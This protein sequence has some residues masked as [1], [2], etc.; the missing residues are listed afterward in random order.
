MAKFFQDGGSLSD[1]LTAI[2]MGGKPHTTLMMESRGNNNP[3]GNDNKVTKQPKGEPTEDMAHQMILEAVAAQ[4]ASV[5]LGDSAEAVFMWASS[6]D[7]SYDSLDAYAQS[8]AGIGDDAE[9]PTDDEMDDYYNVLAEMANFMVS[10]GIDEDA[11]SAFFDEEDDEMGASIA[12]QLND[13]DD[14]EK[15]ELVATYSV[16]GDD[17]MTEALKKVVRN[18]KVKLIRKP[19]KKRRRTAAQRMA[20]KKAQ[21]KASTAQAKLH[22]KK[23]MKLRAKRIG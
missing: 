11:V 2:A 15:D 12:S 16:S 7:T 5:S 6:D 20:L 1:A 18:G 9:E 14:D 21:R 8:L 13:I 17:T 22:R 10:V 19:F 4:L 3:E 23:S